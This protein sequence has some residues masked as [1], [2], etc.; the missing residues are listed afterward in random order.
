MESDLILLRILIINTFNCSRKCS[1]QFQV[2]KVDQGDDQKRAEESEKGDDDEEHSETGS[3]DNSEEHSSGWSGG[4]SDTEID[5]ESNEYV[6]E[7]ISPASCVIPLFFV[8]LWMTMD[9]VATKTHN[10]KMT[11]HFSDVSMSFVWIMALSVLFS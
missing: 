3:G 5:R 2:A 7:I 9:G 6:E 4:E 1:G 8:E 11:R 10:H